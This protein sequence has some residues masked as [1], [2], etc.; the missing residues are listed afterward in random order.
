[1]NQHQASNLTY[2]LEVLYRT[3]TEW[4]IERWM[5]YEWGCVIRSLVVYLVQIFSVWL[6]L[7]IY[8]VFSFWCSSDSTL[9]DCAT[10]ENCSP[11]TPSSSPSASSSHYYCCMD[12][13]TV[14]ALPSSCNRIVLPQFHILCTSIFSSFPCCNV[15]DVELIYPD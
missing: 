13:S 3:K 9:I 14:M 8:L 5:D 6:V 1:M 12:F 2:N 11:T 10:G 15:K 7:S 4:E